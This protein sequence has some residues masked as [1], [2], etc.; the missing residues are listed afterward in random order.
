[1]VAAAMPMQASEMAPSAAVIATCQQRQAEFS[2]LMARWAALQVR[3]KA[4]G[5]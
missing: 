4:A 5:L 3:L 1:M 2:A